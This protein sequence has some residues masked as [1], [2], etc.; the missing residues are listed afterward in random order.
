MSFNFIQYRCRVVS[1]R[2]DQ[3]PLRPC[4]VS[5]SCCWF[6]EYMFRVLYF[7]RLL[8]VSELQCD[9]DWFLEVV[10]HVLNKPKPFRSMYHNLP[11]PSKK[12]GAHESQLYFLKAQDLMEN[13]IGS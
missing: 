9:S 8:D 5:Q 11:R 12:A 4:A 13:L 7:V 10:R 2:K 3:F 6:Y 1:H